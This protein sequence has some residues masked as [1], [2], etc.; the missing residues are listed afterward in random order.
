MT[1]QSR[2][3]TF[4]VMLEKWIVK[5]NESNFAYPQP[6]STTAR[7]EAG[8]ISIRIRPDLKAPNMVFVTIHFTE[9]GMDQE[10]A[11]HVKIVFSGQSEGERGFDRRGIARLP[12]I[13]R[14]A[15]NISLVH[16]PERKL[17]PS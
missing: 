16:T 1:T 15:S 14:S 8:I 12:H 11:R 7:Y 3:H 6:D 9:R 17:H 4:D 2:V 10:Y 13:S 5:F